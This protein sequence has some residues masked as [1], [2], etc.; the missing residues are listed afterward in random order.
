MKNR[1]L[2]QL[3]EIL[4]SLGVVAVLYQIGVNVKP[5]EE[6]IRVERRVI[7]PRDHFYGAAALGDDPA[8]RW[9]V[10]NEG[11]ILRSQDGGKS[12]IVQASGTKEHLQGIAAWDSQRAVAVGN[13]GLIIITADGGKT[14]APSPSPK[15]QVD[16]KLLRVRIDPRGVAWA[17]GNMGAVL[18]STDFGASW[19]RRMPIQD[20]AWN[21]IGFSDAGVVW[22]VGEFG[23]IMHSTPV[24][25]KKDSTGANTRLQLF[26]DSW[27]AAKAPTDRSL[28]AIKFF[29]ARQAF[30]AGLE[31]T[32]IKTED[33]G[34]TWVSVPLMTKEHLLALVFAGGRWVAVGTRGLLVESD[35]ATGSRWKEGLVG[36]GDLTWHTDLLFQQDQLFIVGATLHLQNFAKSLQ[37]TT[38]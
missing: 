32:L 3:L 17:V 37:F 16:N 38:R 27:T 15:S 31:G 9:V 36:S 8:V 1:K 34:I 20:V 19:S 7:E 14:W 4:F 35:D 24:L 33:G 10:G 5:K 22:V 13:D 29:G 18:A 30:A 21:D 23:R 26:S 2:F 25:E 11:K 6:S 28:M 12:W